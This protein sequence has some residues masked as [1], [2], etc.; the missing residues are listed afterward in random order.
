MNT[1]QFHD[2]EKRIKEVLTGKAYTHEVIVDALR[3]YYI[4]ANDFNTLDIQRGLF[5]LLQLNEKYNGLER[6]WKVYNKKH[7]KNEIDFKDVDEFINCLFYCDF[8][9]RR[10]VKSGFGFNCAVAVK[11]NLDKESNILTEQISATENYLK[12]LKQGDDTLFDEFA[13]V[14]KIDYKSMNP[15]QLEIIKNFYKNTIEYGETLVKQE[16]LEFLKFF[17]PMFKKLEDKLSDRLNTTVE[18]ILKLIKQYNPS[19]VVREAHD[20]LTDKTYSIVDLANNINFKSDEEIINFVLAGHGPLMFFGQKDDKIN[21]INGKTV[22]NSNEPQYAIDVSMMT[23]EYQKFYNQF[24]NFLLKDIN[25]QDYKYF[26][27]DILELGPAFVGF[28]DF[29]KFVEGNLLQIMEKDKI[30]TKIGISLKRDKRLNSILKKEALRYKKMIDTVYKNTITKT[31][32]YSSIVNKNKPE[33]NIPFG[34]F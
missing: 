18:D 12:V 3:A 30:G 14:L 15:S 7:G 20:K 2:D 4:V 11:N 10:I 34:E 16:Q 6:A 24:F 31:K 8:E 5:S 22:C 32:N 9:T 1:Y 29:S 23:E 27:N 17:L 28:T 33:E 26:V 13:S 25:L 21:L 19:I